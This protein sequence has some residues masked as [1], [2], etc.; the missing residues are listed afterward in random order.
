MFCSDDMSPSLQHI[1][2]QYL[3]FMCIYLY[4]YIDMDSRVCKLGEVLNPG[5]SSASGPYGTHGPMARPMGVQACGPM[6][7]VDLPPSC[8]LA[9]VGPE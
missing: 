6:G 7:F 4:I 1:C 8:H 2:I 5:T 9:Y 3:Y